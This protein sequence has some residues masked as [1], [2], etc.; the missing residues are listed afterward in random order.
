MKLDFDNPLERRTLAGGRVE[1]DVVRVGELPVLRISHAPGWRWSLHSAEENGHARCHNVH[2]GV[3]AAG[4][5]VVQPAAGAAYTV[6]A[7]DAVAI[8]PG[9]D[10][11]TIGDEPAVLIQFDEGPSSEARYRLS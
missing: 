9:H 8:A 2:V 1:V 10:A 6:G 7:G 3:M 11:W 4:A 5:M